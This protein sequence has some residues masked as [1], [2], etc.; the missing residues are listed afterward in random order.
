MPI[1]SQKVKSNVTNIGNIALQFRFASSHK[2]GEDDDDDGDEGNDGDCFL[3][4]KLFVLGIPSLTYC[5]WL[6]KKYSTDV[7]TFRKFS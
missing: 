2:G 3:F 6:K 7:C 5:L 4:G 1:V